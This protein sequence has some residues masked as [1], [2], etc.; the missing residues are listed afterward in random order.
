MSEGMET[1]K[2]YWD[3]E[4]LKDFS[5]MTKDCEICGKWVTIKKLP[6]SLI[7][8]VDQT[9]TLDFIVEGLVNPKLTKEQAKG[10]PIDFAK[11]LLDAITSF[12][13]LSQKDAEKN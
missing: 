2:N 12:S 9:S 4:S 7:N 10:L 1:V 5:S 6:I 13:A 8:E 3:I 11:G